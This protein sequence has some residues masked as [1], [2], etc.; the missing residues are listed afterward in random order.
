MVSSASAALLALDVE[1]IELADSVS[2]NDGAF[3]ERDSVSQL[4]RDSGAAAMSSAASIPWLRPL[5]LLSYVHRRTSPRLL[6]PPIL[7]RIDCIAKELQLPPGWC[8]SSRSLSQVIYR[9]TSAASAYI[10]SA[11]CYQAYL[12]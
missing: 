12:A 5:A 11:W 9:I 1:Y 6:A 4:L 2:E 3:M 7:R 8:H 10:W